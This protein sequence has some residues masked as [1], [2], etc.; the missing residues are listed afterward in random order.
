[1]SHRCVVL[2]CLSLVV[3]AGAA[4]AWQPADGKTDKPAT[5]PT[6]P[7]APAEKPKA[8]PK[9]AEPAKEQFVYVE[10]KT[11]MGPIVLEL[12]KEKAPISVENF[13]SYL[14]KG[15]YDGTIFHRVISTF[16]I[17]GGGFTADM[18]QKKTEKPIKNEWQNGLKNVRGTIAMARLGN[19][20]PDPKTVDSATCQFFINVQDNA[21]LDRPQRD[22]GAYAVFGKVVSGMEVV[23]K[24]RA[25]KT[26]IKNGFEDVPIETVTIEKAR[27]LS[28]EES[29]KFAGGEKK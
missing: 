6:A 20:R 14:D 23:D 1:M 24:I 28:A 27:R 19:N 13:L 3:A 17:Q 9:A 21:G 18:Q 29:A 4:L 15:H 16:M 2:S 5:Q 25:V 10:L 22:G 7:A 8:D 12:N 11:S 26:G